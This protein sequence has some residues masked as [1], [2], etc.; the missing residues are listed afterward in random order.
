[1]LSTLKLFQ[2][3]FSKHLFYSFFYENMK[4]ITNFLKLLKNANYG[5]RNSKNVEINI[6]KCT[7]VFNF[8]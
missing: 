2:C 1:M 5:K 7:Q 6:Y 3:T 8:A 4:H